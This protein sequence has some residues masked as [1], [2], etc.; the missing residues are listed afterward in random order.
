[1]LQ[2]QN[3]VSATEIIERLLFKNVDETLK[4]NF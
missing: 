1:M 4:Q 2:P 3:Q